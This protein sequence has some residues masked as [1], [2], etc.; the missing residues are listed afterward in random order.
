MLRF[1][2]GRSIL[3]DMVNGGDVP[4]YRAGGSPSPIAVWV[5][6]GAENLAASLVNLITPGTHN[7]TAD[8]T[9]AL[10]ELGWD[11]NN[12][13]YLITDLVPG[14]DW[15]VITKHSNQNDSSR[16]MFGATTDATSNF[17]CRHSGTLNA[18]FLNGNQGVYVYGGFSVSG[19]MGMAGKTTFINGVQKDTIVAGGNAPTHPLFLMA[20]NNAG[21]PL[22][23]MTQ[24]HLVAAAVW[25]STLTPAQ[26]IAVQTAL[27]NEDH[28]VPETYQTPSYTNVGGTGDRRSVIGVSVN[29]A[30]A[31][32]WGTIVSSNN[33]ANKTHIN[34][35]T[36]TSGGYMANNIAVAGAWYEFDFSTLAAKVLIT[37]ARL[38]VTAAHVASGVFKWQ[39]YNGTTW[40]DVGGTFTLGV[41]GVSGLVQTFDTLSGNTKGYSK[42]RI[43]GVSGNSSWNMYYWS[44]FEFKIG[45]ML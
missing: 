31:S 19:V 5:G 20:L 43:L 10:E 41:T 3:M 44:E 34:G 35:N 33:V 32:V 24:G 17:Y 26:M 7:L 25:N 23:K 38:H 39:G 16:F 27:L 15:T 2:P 14:L 42:Y 37:E 21:S 29:P 11:A 6:R 36:A 40:E 4:W 13:M 28:G 45:A 22:S 8:G 18:N 9:A 1:G 30:D 12:S